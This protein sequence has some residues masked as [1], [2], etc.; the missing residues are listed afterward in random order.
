MKTTNLIFTVL[1]LTLLMSGSTTARILNVPDDF[2]T[3]QAAIDASE[4]ADT[5]LVQPGEYVENIDFDGHN[6]VV[7]SLFLTIGDTTFVERTIIDG[8]GNG[9]V[10]LISSGESRN[11]VLSGLTIQ[12][13][14]GEMG[15][16][17]FI[18][19]SSPTLTQLIIQNNNNNGYNGGGIYM[20]RGEPVLTNVTIRDNR[21]NYGAGITCG[22]QCNPILNNCSILNNRA[23]GGAG[24]KISGENT[25]FILNNVIIEGN[26]ASDEG[27]GIRCA[28]GNLILNN[29]IVTGNGAEEGGGINCMWYSRVEMTNVTISN[30]GA[31]WGGGVYCNIGSEL[32]ITNSNIIG[33]SASMGG[34]LCV[35]CDNTLVRCILNN[36]SI[37]DNSARS[38]GGGIYFEGPCRME[39]N[40]DLEMINVTIANNNAE[41]DGGGI[42][43]VDEAHAVL[44]N[45]IFWN[46]AP[47]QVFAPRRNDLNLLSLGYSN[48]EGGE[49]GIED[50]GNIDITWL[51]GNINAD[52]LFVNP[53]EGE[54]HLTEDSPCIDTGNPESEPNPDGT[55]ADMGAF[56]FHQENPDP[57]IY[58][59]PERI[60]FGLIG[61]GQRLDETLLI[62]N[63][64]G[65]ILH[66]Q[67]PVFDPE[68]APVSI[69]IPEGE[70][71]V[72]P[73]SEINL[74]LR[75]EP[76][77]EGALDA[78]MRLQSDDPDEEIV[79]IP[80]S[81]R[82][83]WAAPDIEV[84]PEIAEF[85]DI[86]VGAESRMNIRITNRGNFPLVFRDLSIEPGNSGFEVI[87]NIESDTLD[88]EQGLN[89]ILGFL[90]EDARHY[91][92]TLLIESND[93]DEEFF[94]LLMFG[95]AFRMA[96]EIQTNPD[97]VWFEATDLGDEIEAVLIIENTGRT[98]LDIF[99]Q[100]IEPLNTP[101]SI[102]EGGGEF[103]LRPDRQHRTIL[104]FEANDWDDYNAMF[105]IQSN[106][107]EEAVKE[108]PIIGRALGVSDNC[109]Y[110]PEEFRILR[111][112]P[113]PFNSV[114]KITYS[115]PISGHVVLKI[116]DL[117]GREVENIFDGISPVGIHANPWNAEGLAPGLYF[118]RLADGM[119]TDTRKVVLV[120]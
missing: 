68:N 75:Y 82:A 106:D 113:N 80:I 81:G 20:D 63:Y 51:E 92:A 99:D 116:F 59:T 83:L 44:V 79:E 74:I 89:L 15:G 109:D 47:E 42:Y 118:V 108:I 69:V 11:T 26:A 34:G 97:T 76:E 33:N 107:P 53:D 7:G 103:T 13:G 56:Y 112:Y 111:T 1:I 100:Y 48:I 93:P 50:N 57:D 49:N 87:Q 105:V 104:S 61:V 88:V 28:Y 46:N 10:V 70:F 37:C 52:P 8:D 35:Y 86:T 27:G 84:E 117:Y 114:T 55:R 64:G 65:E 78:V 72:E 45:G 115:T 85:G 38:Q 2:E 110:H 102:T 39:N 67:V 25:T 58:I 5:V 16:G 14:A 71:E 73:Q 98:S 18:R 41:N 60:N 66:V 36:V 19:N 62:R 29:V 96:P 90:P 17:M 43:M 77:E 40:N 54:Y 91:E 21:A 23:S 31:L 24:I 30:N 32:I 101:F 94:E 6:I 4:D 95:R 22:D 120:K 119:K 9:S 3:I 12:N